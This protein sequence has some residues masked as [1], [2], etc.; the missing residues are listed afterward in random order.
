MY[1]TLLD[2]GVQVY[3]HQGI[4]GSLHHK[5][6]VVDHSEPQSDPTVITGS[7]NWSSTAENTNDENTLFVHDA[8]VSNLYYQEFVGLLASMGIESV[9]DVDG[10]LLAVVYPNPTTSNL[11]MEIDEKLLGEQFTVYDVNGRGVIQLTPVNIRSSFDVSDLTSGIYFISSPTLSQK[12]RLVI[13]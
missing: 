4:S 3:S 10:N 13:Q 1:N 8:R 5:Y 7:H 11:L 2:A 9:G 12:I 6:A